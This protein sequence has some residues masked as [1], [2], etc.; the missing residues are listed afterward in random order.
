MH[1]S[2]QIRVHG[3]QYKVEMCFKVHFTPAI[4][5]QALHLDR[6]TSRS[7]ATQQAH[8]VKQADKAYADFL[9]EK[10]MLSLAGKATGTA[11]DFCEVL[12][13]MQP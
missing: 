3:A 13:L 9:G 6:Q 4:P 12:P 8:L 1:P 2:W 5:S 11:P 7:P 10:K